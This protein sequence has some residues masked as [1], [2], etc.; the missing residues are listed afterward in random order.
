MLVA[1]ASTQPAKLARSAEVGEASKPASATRPADATA[2]YHFMLGYQA[3]LAQNSE[4]ALKEY[5]AALKADPTALS[6]KA[7]L[8]SLH[9]S[10][11]DMPNALRYAEEV[12]D[13]QADDARM[14]THIAVILAGAGKGEKALSV[15]DR[16]IE[17]EPEASEAYFSKGLLLL[18]LKRPAEAEQA[19]RGGIARSPDNAVGHY[20]LGRILLETGKVD[21]A[22][23]SFERAITV[24]S[25]F[26]PAY[27]ALASMH[28][29]RHERDKA[30]AVL[31]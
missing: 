21:D 26:E 5:Q 9:F 29:A 10:L 25:A 20:H 13:G 30:I 8:A 22:I 14:L 3:E 24:N 11:G 6:V 15:L 19:M 31:K 16:A 17:L 27:L 4:L 12:A 2:A 18:N 7:R 23:A 28:E 1:C